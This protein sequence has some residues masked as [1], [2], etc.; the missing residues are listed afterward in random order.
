MITRYLL[1]LLF[2][3]AVHI[4]AEAQVKNIN[5]TV[6]RTEDLN[7][8]EPPPLAECH[9]IWLLQ[10]E[11]GQCFRKEMPRGGSQGQDLC[12]TIRVRVRRLGRDRPGWLLPDAASTDRLYH[13]ET[14]RSHP[15]EA[16]IARQNGHY[17]DLLGRQANGHNHQNRQTQAEE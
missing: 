14:G 16:A 4:P 7:S 9:R 5:I 15:R 12:P 3:V 10:C 13:S 1:F 2:I 11:Q 8:K 6:H 17:S